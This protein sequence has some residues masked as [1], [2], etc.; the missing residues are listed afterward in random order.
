[1]LQNIRFKENRCELIKLVSSELS[2]FFFFFNKRI[3]PG[4]QYS[5]KKWLNSLHLFS[6][7]SNAKRCRHL[8][9]LGRIDI[10]ATWG[11]RSPARC[12]RD[13]DWALNFLEI[14]RRDISSARDVAEERAAAAKSRAG[15]Q[16]PRLHWM[17]NA[18]GPQKDLVSEA[19]KQGRNTL[20]S[21]KKELTA[22]RKQLPR[23][24]WSRRNKAKNL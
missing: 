20:I 22:P 21:R 5:N 12:K 15:H 2:N 9:L 14:L 13:G 11:Q 17:L 1:M 16:G 10:N 19:W 3:Y 18:K 6:P 8:V 7:I 23:N 4:F 24:S